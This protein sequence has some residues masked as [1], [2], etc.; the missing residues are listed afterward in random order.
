MLEIE[1][2]RPEAVSEA[3]TEE[4][5]PEGEHMGKSKALADLEASLVRARGDH[6]VQKDMHI[7]EPEPVVGPGSVPL[8]VQCQES[9][10]EVGLTKVDLE[11][12]SV[13]VGLTKHTVG[14][15]LV[16]VPGW[17]PLRVQG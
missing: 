17:V 11:E 6:R 14:P 12:S 15:E 1:G 9:T 16:V 5:P 10:M 3:S 2:K 13:E 4:L 8:L 7:V